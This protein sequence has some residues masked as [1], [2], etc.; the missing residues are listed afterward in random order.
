MESKRWWIFTFGCGQKNAGHYVRFFGTYGS[1]RQQMFDHFGDEWAFQYAEEE[2][3][4]N[5]TEMEV[6]DENNN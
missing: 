3:N 5:E 4:G 2:F 1:A 6:K